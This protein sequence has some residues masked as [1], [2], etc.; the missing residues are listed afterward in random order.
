M[1]NNAQ[2]TFYKHVFAETYLTDPKQELSKSI[3]KIEWQ[4]ENLQNT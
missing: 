4:L 3:K 1:D 2:N